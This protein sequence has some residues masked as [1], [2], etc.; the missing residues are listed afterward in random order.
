MPDPAH[1]PARQILLNRFHI[2]IPSSVV[3]LIIGGTIGYITWGDG[4][5]ANHE[6]FTKCAELALFTIL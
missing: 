3:L 1:G 2:R 4:D 6:M 5:G